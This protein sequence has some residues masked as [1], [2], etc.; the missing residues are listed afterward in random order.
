MIGLSKTPRALCGKQQI[1]R[2]WTRVP[3]YLT[4]TLRGSRYILVPLPWQRI[5][6]IFLSYITVSTRICHSNETPLSGGGNPEGQLRSRR[7]AAKM[8]VAVVLT[9]AICFFP[10]HLLSI[11]RYSRRYLQFYGVHARHIARRRKQE[12]HEHSRTER[13]I[14]HSKRKVTSS[15]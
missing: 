8:L 7:K 9:F 1:D 6:L 11:L 4:R 2:N 14:L 5:S 13:C 10:V 12:Q 15:K 3:V